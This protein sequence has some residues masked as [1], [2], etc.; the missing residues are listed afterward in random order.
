M[1]EITYT[2]TLGV[3]FTWIFTEQIPVLCLPKIPFLIPPN[4]YKSLKNENV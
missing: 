3:V 1:E 4:N 2:M